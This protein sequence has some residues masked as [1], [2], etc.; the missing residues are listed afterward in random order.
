MA[1]QTIKAT[2]IVIKEIKTK[3]NDK[4]IIRK[5]DGK[6]NII[7]K[8]ETKGD[9]WYDGDFID[10]K[11]YIIE[12]GKITALNAKTGKIIWQKKMQDLQEI[13]QEK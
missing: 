2:G 5:T 7:W 10:D 6:D 11:L 3:E 12:E 4:I 13:L 8:Y 1:N 9:F